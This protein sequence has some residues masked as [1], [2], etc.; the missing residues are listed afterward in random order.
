[1][2]KWDEPHVDGTPLPALAAYS[3]K[4]PNC[5]SL[6]GF[7]CFLNV[8]LEEEEEFLKD[9]NAKEYVASL[10]DEEVQAI[11][12]EEDRDPPQVVGFMIQ[13]QH[14]NF[15]SSWDVRPGEVLYQRN[16]HTDDDIQ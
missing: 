6:D 1:M 12:D 15:K 16:V 5:G 2:A 9:Y 8:P 10:S 11:I 7:S 14:C 13:C 3:V 4:C